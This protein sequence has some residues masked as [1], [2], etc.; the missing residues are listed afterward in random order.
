MQNLE[1]FL[2]VHHGAARFSTLTANGF[3]RSEINRAVRCG[4]LRHP[5]PGTYALPDA[6]PELLFAAAHG[7]SLTCISAAKVLGWWILADPGHV[8]VAADRATGLTG[9]VVHRGPR[10]AKR[11]IAVPAQILTAAF[12]CLPPLSALVM[13]ECAVSRNQIGSRTLEQQFS[14]SKDWRIRQLLA[15]IR[16]GTASPLEVCARFHL[17]AAGLSVQVEVPIPGVGRVDLWWRDG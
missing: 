11:L 9:T 1:V 14:G 17:Q 12:R 2:R 3:R 8:H 4:I 16:P 15:E 6:P 13:A 7:V 5:G 10:T